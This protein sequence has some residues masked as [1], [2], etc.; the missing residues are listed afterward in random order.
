MILAAFLTAV[1]VYLLTLYVQDF[2][3]EKQLLKRRL[4][5]ITLNAYEGFQRA[6]SKH[7]AASLF[8][9]KSRKQ[10]DVKLLRVL[11][12]GALVVTLITYQLMP[13]AAVPIMVIAALIIAYLFL[14][15]S[16]KTR[17]QN[18]IRME[19]P[20]AMDLMIICLSSGL[21]ISAA[22][23]R[24]S[25]E[26][27][28]SPL[29]NE[30]RQV[31]NET[32]T[33]MPLEE[34]LKNFSVRTNIPEVTTIIASIIQAYKSG[35]SIVDTF[36]VQGEFLR[37]KIKFGQKERFSR[38]PVLVLIPLAFFFIPVIFVFVLAPQI[39]RVMKQGLF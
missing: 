18:Q 3:H 11:S 35:A 9:Q 15:T 22:L 1:S 13:A 6:A 25:H 12:I 28:D 19:L 32:N 33:G 26:M 24:V 34:G 30:F 20:G 17:K 29:G 23:E 38:I 39:L 31:V 4:E 8:R 5:K 2:V 16:L 7:Q 27:E 36:Q 10:A 14:V 37:D 21:G